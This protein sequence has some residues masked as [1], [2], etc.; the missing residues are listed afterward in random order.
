MHHRSNKALFVL[1]LSLAAVGCGSTHEPLSATTGVYDLTIAGEAD[2]C[3]PMRMTGP[4]GTAGVVQQGAV[5]T[6]SVPDLTNSALMLVSLDS[7]SSFSDERMDTLASCTNATL[8]RSYSVVAHDAGGFDVAYHESW[9]GLST[10]G[11]A[12]RVLMPAAPS[13]DC[14]AD[15]VMHY[16]LATPCA[17]PCQIRVTADGAAACHC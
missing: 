11:A 5:L 10:C 8:A 14:S 2:A 1:V 13:T 7:A 12:M 16:R 6:L 4:M 3:S 9:S 17:S 15:L